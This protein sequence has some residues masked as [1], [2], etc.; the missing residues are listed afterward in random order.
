MLRVNGETNSLDWADEIAVF[1]GATVAAAREVDNSTLFIAG[2]NSHVAGSA[3]ICSTNAGSIR[4][5]SS[6]AEAP[7]EDT[8]LIRL[9]SAMKNTVITSLSSLEIAAS[10]AGAIGLGS[11]F[12]LEYVAP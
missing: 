1:D 12:M 4:A 6:Y 11:V 8:P 3:V 5:V 10:N 9:A 2:A 7:A